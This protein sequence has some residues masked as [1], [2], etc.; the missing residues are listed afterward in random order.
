M[1]V[2]STDRRKRI[3]VCDQ[4]SKCEHSDIFSFLRKSEFCFEKH[5][6][7]AKR[8]K[9]LLVFNVDKV[10]LNSLERSERSY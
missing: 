10:K 6:S 2:R 5:V 3:S 9:S 1:D 7:L 8:L 4:R